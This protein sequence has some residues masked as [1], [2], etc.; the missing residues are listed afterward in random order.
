MVKE[1][2]HVVETWH[3]IFKSHCYIKYIQI[4]K[5]KVHSG[6]EAHRLHWLQNISIYLSPTILVKTIILLIVAYNVFKNKILFH[7]IS[8][9]Q[10]NKMTNIKSK[11]DMERLSDSKKTAAGVRGGWG[12]GTITREDYKT[13]CIALSTHSS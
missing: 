9:S 4:Y 7:N 3:H 6:I 2:W 1:R 11:T 12:R 5:E 8:K 13:A 10:L